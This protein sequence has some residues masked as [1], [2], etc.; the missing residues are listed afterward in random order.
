MLNRHHVA[1]LYAHVD[2]FRGC[3]RQERAKIAALTTDLRFDAGKV[4]CQQGSPG[5]EAF[6]IVDG[7]AS[8]EIDGVEVATLG[9]NDV[10]GEMALLDGGPRV[11]TVTAT[12]PIEVLVLTRKEF[13]SML[14]ASPAIALRVLTAVGTRLRAAETHAAP[15]GV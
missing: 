1:D 4:L 5:L 15:V 7:A 13:T 12:T 9:P 14:A 3:T 8:V 6:V 10:F 2:L 11:A